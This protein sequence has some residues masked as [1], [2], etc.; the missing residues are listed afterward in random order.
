MSTDLTLSVWRRWMAFSPVAWLGCLVAVL[1]GMTLPA[2][3]LTPV[4][5]A[6]ARQAASAW[7]E[8]RLAWRKAI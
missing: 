7:L 1:A 8:Q 4:G 5:E 2:A 3:A 6:E